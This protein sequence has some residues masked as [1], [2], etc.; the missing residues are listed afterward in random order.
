MKSVNP[1]YIPIDYS[2]KMVI[3]LDSNKLIPMLMKIYDEKGVFEMYEYSDVELN[4]EFKSDDFSIDN[5][6]YNF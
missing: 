5:K 3:Y 6:S 1:N 4:N 2:P